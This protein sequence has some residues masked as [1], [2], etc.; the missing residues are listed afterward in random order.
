MCGWEGDDAHA[1]LDFL[2]EGQEGGGEGA[3][4]GRGDEELDGLVVGE[5]GHEL[6]ALLFAKWGQAGVVHNVVGW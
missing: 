2:V 5:G 1:A 6:L 4:E 3:A